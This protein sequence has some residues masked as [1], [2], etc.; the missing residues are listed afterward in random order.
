MCDL[1]GYFVLVQN[2]KNAEGLHFFLR[3][4]DISHNVDKIKFNNGLPGGLSLR[5]SPCIP[6]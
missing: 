1:G 4:E 5:S 2:F 3:F 6:F